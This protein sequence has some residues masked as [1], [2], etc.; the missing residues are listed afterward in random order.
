[1]TAEMRML[2]DAAPS[3]AL[4]I[5]RAVAYLAGV[6]RGD[7]WV[8]QAIGLRVADREFA[9]AFS[10]ALLCAYGVAAPAKRDERGYWLVRKAPGARFAHLLRYEPGTDDERAAWLRGMFDSE[11]N[12]LCVPK[13]SVGPLSWDRRVALY[14][15]DTATLDAAERHL[16]ALGL[17]T[18]RTSVKPSAG[19]LGSRPVYE[20]RLRAGREH[21]ARFVAV[22]GSTIPRK[23]EVL[24][25]LPTTYVDDVSACRRTMQSRGVATRV[26]RREA[27]GRY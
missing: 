13:P 7:G 16:A 8:G 22:V 17:P 20:L 18:R 21:Y 10:E 14:G 25:L 3:G 19:H 15:T 5:E 24:V 26:A 12:A 6:V 2:T 11:G 4:T 9:D 27:G 23:A 1:M